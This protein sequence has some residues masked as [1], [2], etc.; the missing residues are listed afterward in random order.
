MAETIR[1]AAEQ[2]NLEV[3]AGEAAD[4]VIT[5]QNLGAAVGVFTIEVEGLDANWYSLSG[6]SV[7]LFPGDSTTTTL[8]IVPPRMS[9]S[10][11]KDYEFSVNV[12]SQRDVEDVET[13]PFTLKLNPFY[14]FALDY[15]P[16]RARGASAE[17]T[18]TLSN[19]GNA[20]ITFDLEARDTD[21]LCTF[22]FQPESPTVAPGQSGQVVVTAKGKRPLRGLPPLYQ[23][24]ITATPSNGEMEARSSFAQ[25]EVPPRIPG[26]TI[27]AAMFTVIAVVIAVGVF[28][29]LNAFLWAPVEVDKLKVA[30]GFVTLTEGKTSQ[31]AAISLDG[32]GEIL[33]DQPV[34]WSST[35][36]RVATVSATG[37]QVRAIRPGTAIITPA[38]Q[39]QE[40]DSSNVVGASVTVL[41]PIL[42][43]DCLSYDPDT[44]RF[45]VS[46]DA[47][48]VIT[49]DAGNEVLTLVDGDDQTNAMRL[50]SKHRERCFIGR[51][52][53]VAERE[54][55]EIEF[56]LSRSGEGKD[57]GEIDPEDCDS[58]NASTTAIRNTPTGDWI[59]V[60]NDSM[61]IVMDDQEDAEAA[62]QLARSHSSRC[63]VGRTFVDGTQQGYLSQY[64]K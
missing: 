16:Q 27:R 13:L 50:A 2:M 41:Q 64:W 54:V 36:D 38:L 62:L 56:W 25:L 12:S 7:S 4:T 28:Y 39:N 58:Y 5:V 63:F 3:N 8:V 59:L 61:R 19:T 48:L 15:Q 55:S 30:T 20:E 14:D 29:A 34:I 21:G 1:V 44:V 24:E 9:T 51:D 45:G 31:L 32:A 40:L 47:R 6:N 18:L 37:G 17:H 22:D 46:A 26:W 43:T 57:A 11:A 42:S 53:P 23:Y 10:L 49:D 52:A 33:P 35:N 60:D